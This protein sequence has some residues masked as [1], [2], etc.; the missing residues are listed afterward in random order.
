MAPCPQTHNFICIEVDFRR[1]NIPFLFR[2]IRFVFS[3]S[4]SVFRLDFFFFVAAFSY[5]A[6]VPGSMLHRGILVLLLLSAFLIVFVFLCP[7]EMCYYRRCV[8]LFGVRSSTHIWWPPRTTD[9]VCVCEWRV[10]GMDMMG[11][12]FSSCCRYSYRQAGRPMQ[13]E[14][15]EGPKLLAKVLN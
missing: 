15:K 9:C 1:V 8:L 14:R 3:C 11:N 2:S 10:T 7:S 4:A 6:L 12:S 13:Q 5:F